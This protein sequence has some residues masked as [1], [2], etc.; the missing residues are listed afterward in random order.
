MHTHSLTHSSIGTFRQWRWIPSV[1]SSFDIISSLIFCSY[2]CLLSLSLSLSIVVLV[3][4]MKQ[5]QQYSIHYCDL[6]S[7]ASVC[8]C[9]CIVLPIYCCCCCCNLP[10]Q[11]NSRRP[12]PQQANTL[13]CLLPSGARAAVS[14]SRVKSGGKSTTL[15]T[16][17]R[18]RQR[19]ESSSTDTIMCA[20]SW[21]PDERTWV[22]QQRGDE[23]RDGSWC[24]VLLEQL[25]KHTAEFFSS[26]SYSSLN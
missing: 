18:T 15:R 21:T 19:P 20:T 3:V 14:S 1:N 23:S 9:Q 24:T 26:S 2:C 10:I 6:V 22:Q 7:S 16:I 25:L 4:M 11:Q 5:H 8:L 12:V 17:T 13:A